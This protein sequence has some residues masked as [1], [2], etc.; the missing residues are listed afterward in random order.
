M[1][2]QDTR[3]KHLAELAETYHRDRHGD[4]ANAYEDFAA[5]YLGV[6]G[7]DTDTSE[8]QQLERE[9]EAA[10]GRG[11]ELAE[12][13]DELRGTPP[14][15]EIPRYA[16]VR[17]DE[18]YGMID[19]SDS[20]TFAIRSES[21]SIGEEYLMNPAG[22]YDLD[23]GLR[24]ETVQVGMSKEAYIV[25]CGLVQPNWLTSEPEECDRCEGEGFLYNEATAA[26]DLPCPKCGTD[27]VLNLAVNHGGI[28][29]EA[30][31]ELRSAFPLETFR[32]VA[33]ERGED[34]Y[35]EEAGL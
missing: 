7:T 34:F 18:T 9:F 24:I 14:T 17:D 32:R 19:V 16:A 8:L 3:H 4:Y 13:I 15:E 10:G 30:W 21:G 29:S 25:L 1:A 22:V 12:R 35:D 23:T 11:V 28:Y 31:D 33:Q 6:P 5:R 26:T 27:G 2:D 20:L